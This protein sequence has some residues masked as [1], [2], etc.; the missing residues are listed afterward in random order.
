MRTILAPVAAALLILSQQAHAEWRHFV[1]EGHV[2]EALPMAPLN[3]KVRIKFS[4]DDEQAPLV[5]VGEPN[6]PGYGVSSYRFD[7]KIKLTV[8]GHT[9]H[10]DALYADVTNLGGKDGASI[11]LYGSTP[12]VVDGTTFPV[13]SV[14]ITLVSTEGKRVLKGTALPRHLNLK[15]WNGPNGNYGGVQTDGSGN[16]GLLAFTLDDIQEVP[17][18]S[19]QD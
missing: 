10:A 6:G 19:R 4:Y 18:H 13:G 9:V 17:G 2:T 8:N 7:A 5:S 15:R 3:A 12:I 16:G 11:S 14:Y 1:A